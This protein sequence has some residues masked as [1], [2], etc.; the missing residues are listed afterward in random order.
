MG[1]TDADSAYFQAQDR[2]HTY[3]HDNC[4]S[5]RISSQRDT[6]NFVPSFPILVILVME[7]ICSSETSALTRATRSN[8]PEDGIL[9]Y[10]LFVYRFFV[11]GLSCVSLIVMTFP[12]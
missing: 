3:K 4:H 12:D 2:I 6:V 11:F 8:L 1:P 5:I 9:L 7:V 10:H